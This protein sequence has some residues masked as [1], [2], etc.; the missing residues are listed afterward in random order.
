MDTRRSGRR[1]SA[2]STSTQSITRLSGCKRRLVPDEVPSVED[3]EFFK[4]FVALE[5]FISDN[6]P[7]LEHSA[8]ADEADL[9]QLGAQNRS[10]RRRAAERALIA[11]G[12]HSSQEATIQQPNVVIT[13]PERLSPRPRVDSI[14][15][16]SSAE[17][18]YA[19]KQ[20]FIR[21][22]T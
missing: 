17:A 8:S 6:T 7:S 18:M 13:P 5:R 3:G 14:D 1:K 9:R 20:H 16:T 2:N 15:T 11:I 12:T 10:K 19:G 21:K 22:I 4:E